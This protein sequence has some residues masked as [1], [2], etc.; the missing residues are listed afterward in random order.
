MH[1]H[2]YLHIQK[3]SGEVCMYIQTYT[4][5]TWCVT[6]LGS[7]GGEIYMYSVYMCVCVYI[8]MFPRQF[9]NVQYINMYVCMYIC[10][11]VC[12]HLCVC[13]ESRS[14]VS[15]SLRSHRLYSPWNAP[16]QNTGV[17]SLSL[18]QGIFPTHGSNL[19]LLHCRRILYQ[20][21]HKG[22]PHM[23]MCV[24]I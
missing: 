14:V 6:H 23:Y 24:Y 17:S 20:L 5:P 15:D 22:N 7:V 1:R 9:L 3:V 2:V 19:G 16:G 13:C 12:M 21:S 11:H 4:H 10:V 8:C 18:L